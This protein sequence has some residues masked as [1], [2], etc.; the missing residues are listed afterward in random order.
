MDNQIILNQ[1][2]IDRSVL[3]F[4]YNHQSA[5]TT[6]MHSNAVSKIYLYIKKTCLLA[7]M[8]FAIFPKN[9][10]MQGWRWSSPLNS[11]RQPSLDL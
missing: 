5:F 1:S 2:S 11:L 10:C 9:L 4:K 3:I 8:C 6:H 7:I